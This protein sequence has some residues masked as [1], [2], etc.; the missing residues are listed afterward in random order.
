MIKWLYSIECCYAQEYEILG[1]RSLLRC[2]LAINNVSWMKFEATPW[3]PNPSKAF[4]FE[5]W[6]NFANN[7]PYGMVYVNPSACYIPTLKCGRADRKFSFS[8]QG[9]FELYYNTVDGDY[10]IH[11]GYNVGGYIALYWTG[12]STFN[13]LN[14]AS[15]PD[16]SALVKLFSIHDF[17]GM[18]GW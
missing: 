2:E 10:Y 3:N 4:M 15:E 1:V 6:G 9:Q 5:F 12:R 11:T 13:S 17:N 16:Q 14:V 8:S 7:F 18:E